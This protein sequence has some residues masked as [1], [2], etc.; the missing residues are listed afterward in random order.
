MK[1]NHL[2]VAF[3]AFFAITL[4]SCSESEENVLTSI[5]ADT[6]MIVR[7]NAD[8][9][10][11]SAGA[12]KDGNT[13]TFGQGIENILA[14]MTSGTRSEFM[15][16]MDAL[17]VL[18]YENIYVYEYKSS[19]IATCI[20][21]HPG[22]LADGLE[23]ELGKPHKIDGYSV[24]NHVIILKGNRVWIAENID[25]LM[26]SLE[27]AAKSPASNVD[28]ISKNIGNKDKAATVIANYSALLA[29]NPYIQMAGGKDIYNMY[30][31]H[32]VT[33]SIVFDSNKMLVDGSMYDRDGKAVSIAGK[34]AP[35]ETSFTRLL[36][37]NTILAVA[38]GKPSDEVSNI[39]I[40]SLSGLGIQDV[41]PY[42]EA[43]NGSMAFAVAPPSAFNDI[44]DLSKWT[45]TISAG[46]DKAK[47]EEII[48]MAED[49]GTH[50]IN[51]TRLADQTRFNVPGGIGLMNPAN[52][53]LGY[54]DGMLVASTQ[55]I[56]TD[57][58]NSLAANFNG[59]SSAGVFDI[60]ADGDI[61]KGFGAP[62][63]LECHMS[64]D[65]DKFI[66]ECEFT[67]SPYP[68]IESII[69][70]ATDKKFHRDAADAFMRLSAQ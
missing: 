27:D 62:F 20:T 54:I 33:Y 43:L 15:K 31:G 34:L 29:H 66:S 1:T 67:G 6:G 32:F 37:A 69:V 21:K 9:F 19:P 53:Y 42:I 70:A 49:M 40:E 8:K 17:P 12:Q 18:D 23:K 41:R 39:I 45:L 52:F 63:G 16:L 10:L 36:P 51:V 57:H 11:T 2:I 68:F 55:P 60:P 13:W 56:S 3:F 61:V 44:L 7:L 30:E 26:D 35:I 28:I 5:P 64:G 25:K 58:K 4:I 24:Y 59:H 14:T 65:D 47:A 38:S 48:G 46:Y 50:D 22:A